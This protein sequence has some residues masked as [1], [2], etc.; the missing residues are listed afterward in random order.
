MLSLIIGLQANEGYFVE[1][2]DDPATLPTRWSGTPL[3]TETHGVGRAIKVTN[4]N[5]AARVYLW[6]TLPAAEM[7]GRRVVISGQVKGDNVSTP[8]VSYG[9]VKVMLVYTD[10]SGATIYSNQAAVPQGTF[11]WRNFSFPL[12]V[13]QN[14]ATVTLLIGLELSSG[15]AWFDELRVEADPA[16]LSEKFDDAET[17][18]LSRWTGHTASTIWHAG[19]GGALQI[20]KTGTSGSMTRNTT[21]PASALSGRRVL[22]T[23][24][25]KATEVSSKPNSWN[26]IKMML[27]YTTSDGQ[28]QYP[29]VDIGTGTFDWTS[30][31]RVVV[32]PPNVTS[33]KLYLGLENVSGTVAFDNIKLE[34]APILSAEHF[35]DGNVASR[36]S[37]APYSLVVNGTSLG[38]EIT[39]TN[40]ATNK[41]ITRTLSHTQ[42]R[43]RRI[44]LQALVKATNV[45][46]TA[47]S[48][49]GIKV[50][51]TY[52]KSDGS[53]AY[54]ALN[55]SPASGT[56]GWKRFQSEFPIPEDI[57]SLTLT[58]GLEVASGTVAFDDV[59]I[60]GDS[61]SPYWV[62]PTPNYTGRSVPRLRGMMVDTNLTSAGITTLRSWN[63][64]LVRW[65]LGKLAYETTGLNTP[66]YNTVLESELAKLNALL[67]EFAAG[68]I[69][70]ALDLHSL[71]MF[72]FDSAANQKRLIDTWRTLA[73]RYKVG[74]TN[75]N[76]AVIWAY[77]IA[78]EPKD[79]AWT[80]NL[81]TL[82][83]LSEQVA[84]AIRDGD[85]TKAII[86]EP[87]S[88]WCERFPRLRP[89]RTN[90]VIYSFHYYNPW[91][92]TAQGLNVGAP[93]TPLNYPGMVDGTLW[94]SLKIRS[95]VQPAVDF[96][97]KYNVS[98]YV[99]EFSVLRW[100]PGGATYLQDCV[101][102]FEALGWDWSYH[103]FREWQGWSLEIAASTPRTSTTVSPNPTDRETV[104]RNALAPNV[105]PA[106]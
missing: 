19:Q 11:D 13:P 35:D 71:S 44:T 87:Y 4:P 58:L 95:D 98:I 27:V 32:L 86:I 96:Q 63:V 79:D 20:V 8:P 80:E 45:S 9:G 47:N 69:A 14:A 100:A 94:N 105:T 34:S 39:N 26:G 59:I 62:N 53:Y 49:N 15:T 82:N 17:A 91:T 40:P 97:N 10:T 1:S 7:A 104:I 106:P 3:V 81:L 85:P 43:G 46:A 55:I 68:G 29:Q 36:W 99:G 54:P 66:D 101:N 50:M 21:L 65:Q 41:V 75:A 60:K 92:Y 18:I 89:A 57:T 33:V 56:F 77:D 38:C 74:G 64:N 61:F 25:I 73:A 84:L 23:G 22:L 16:I 5:P 67:P 48:W 102:T 52:Q 88:G 70:V 42:L 37:G 90:N 93:Y 83:E 72:Q 28:T 24:Q 31:Y 12:T 76:N 51:L 78:N 6:S 30:V 2:F 103:A